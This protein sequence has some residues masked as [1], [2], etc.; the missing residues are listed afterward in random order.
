MYRVMVEY[1][2]DG[3]RRVLSY[4]PS[5]HAL[6]SRAEAVAVLRQMVN[7][8]C[9]PDA[10]WIEGPNERAML[11]DL[12]EEVV[13]LRCNS[14]RARARVSAL[15]GPLPS[16]FSF[17]RETGHGGCLSATPLQAHKVRA[18]RIPGVTVARKTD[19]LRRCWE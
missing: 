15:V 11:A 7:R 6:Y 10:C 17:N 18:A 13:F 9:K 8:G 2:R 12:K 19:D 3:K 4:P 5:G 1:E 14:H 16:Y